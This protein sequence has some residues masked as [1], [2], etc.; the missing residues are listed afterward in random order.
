MNSA[1]CPSEIRWDQYVLSPC[2]I[3]CSVRR[4]WI[5]VNF[6]QEKL[7]A[8]LRPSFIPQQGNPFTREDW[9]HADPL[10]S[11]HFCNVDMIAIIAMRF[12]SRTF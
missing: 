4:Y 7:F 12:A 10:Q 9:Y 1:I 2:V 11:H 3:G 6:Q 5:H 8:S